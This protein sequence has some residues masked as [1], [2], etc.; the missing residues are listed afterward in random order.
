MDYPL[1]L[2]SQGEVVRGGSSVEAKAPHPSPP[3]HTGEGVEHP[4]DRVSITGGTAAARN[5]G[6]TAR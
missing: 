1:P 4:T 6:P 3:L 2:L 5:A